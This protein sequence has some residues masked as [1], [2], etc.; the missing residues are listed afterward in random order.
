MKFERVN[1]ISLCD[2]IGD[3]LHGTPIYDDKSDIFFIN[4]NNLKNSVIKINKNTKKVSSSEV[5]KNF[6]ELN[7]KTLLLSINGTLG[8]M[9]FYKNEKI[10][11]G[12][13]VAYLNFKNDLN[14]FFYYYFQI[15]EIQNHFLN[16][17]TGSTIK[18][19]GLGELETLKVLVPNKEIKEDTIK[20]LSILDKKIEVNNNIIDKL[21]NLAKLIFDHWFIQLEF[22][23]KNKKPFSSSK[24]NKV[25]NKKLSLDIPFGWEVKSLSKIA[26]CIMGQSPTGDTYN[27]IEKGL[28]LLNGPADYKNGN[29]FS[30]IYTT[31]PLKKCKKNDLVMCIRATIGNLV[32][33]ENEFCLGRGMAA[34]RPNDK[35]YSEYL[36]FIL[37]N[38]INKFKLYAG[39]SIFKAI[40]KDDVRDVNCLIPDDKIIQQFHE[41]TNPI[42]KKIR[43]KKIETLKIT[44]IKE[45]LLPMLTTGQAKLIN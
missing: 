5:E 31:N 27:K 30:R 43:T 26:E 42:F 2:K 9:A 19:L 16:I 34:V 13:S 6:I 25:F 28:P 38:E 3:G 1:L 20:V 36:Y 32:Y 21:E 23:N 29:L 39:G 22:P 8:E 12:K 10:I 11:L 41:L 35:K 15:E 40:V 24:G 18:N 14:K 44:N 37:Q 7:N 17:A 33:A 4:G 45:W